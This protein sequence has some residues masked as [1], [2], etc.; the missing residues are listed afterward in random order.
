MLL[1]ELLK[2]ISPQT[3]TTDIKSNIPLIA[4]QVLSRFD[5][6]QSFGKALT[7]DQ[8]LFLSNNL[9]K[10]DAYFKSDLGKEVISMLVEDF[11]KFVKA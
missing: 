2:V 9:N 4:Q 6:Y 3:L 1:A 5:A 10:L 8:Q 11:V 7:P